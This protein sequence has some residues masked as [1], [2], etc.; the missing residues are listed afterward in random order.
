[1]KRAG[2][3]TGQTIHIA[4]LSATTIDVLVR[5]ERLDRTTQVTRLTPSTPSFVVEAAP[6]AL[7][8]AAT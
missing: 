1:M 8:V 7:Q 2:G 4:G 5:V 3:L 6:R